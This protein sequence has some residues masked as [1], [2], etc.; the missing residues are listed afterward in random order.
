[1]GERSLGVGPVGEERPDEAGRRTARRL[2][3]NDLGTERGEHGA[4]E[5]APLIGQVEHA[6]R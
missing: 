6:K 4:G 5:V 1:V 3:G 2:D